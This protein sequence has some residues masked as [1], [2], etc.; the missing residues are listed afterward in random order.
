VAVQREMEAVALHGPFRRDAQE[1][2]T[3]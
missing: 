2:S 1:I 3:R